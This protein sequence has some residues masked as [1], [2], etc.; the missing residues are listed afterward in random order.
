MVI[1]A[2]VEKE[3]GS[4]EKTTKEREHYVR[5]DWRMGIVLACGFHVAGQ[6]SNAGLDTGDT[7][8]HG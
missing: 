2:K 6:F 4:R 5:E 8:L 1:R 7:R 3:L